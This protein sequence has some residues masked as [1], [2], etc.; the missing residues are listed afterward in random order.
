MNPI[1][2]VAETSQYF[3]H[4]IAIFP[5]NVSNFTNSLIFIYPTLFGILTRALYKFIAL[6]KGQERTWISNS[7]VDRRCAVRRVIG[8]PGPRMHNARFEILP[9]L[10]DPLP[11][12][13]PP[14]PGWGSHVL[15][16]IPGWR[17]AWI[18][19]RHAR[20]GC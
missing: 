16:P 15:I 2:V 20:D 19:T 7:S 10:A 5:T 11:S 4:A 18:F 1:F 12:P 6:Y 14:S 3:R 9:R 13:L 8:P 17:F